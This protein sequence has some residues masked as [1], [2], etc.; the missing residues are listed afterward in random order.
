VGTCTC[1]YGINTAGMRQFS[2]WLLLGVSVACQAPQGRASHDVEGATA[3]AAPS[4]AA[5]PADASTRAPGAPEQ[6]GPGADAAVDAAAL[7]VPQADAASSAAGADGGPSAQN[8]PLAARCM[9]RSVPGRDSPLPRFTQETIASLPGA[10]YLLPH[11]VNRDG[12]PELLVS[13]LT[14]GLDL[15]QLA[16]GPPLSFGGAYVLSR[17]ASTAP[18]VLPTFVVQKAFDQSAGIAW[19]NAS[20]VFDADGDSV[21]DWLIGAGLL[22]KPVGAL[23]MMRGTPAGGFEP[24][25]SIPVP[26]PSCW[27]HEVLPRDLDG[28]GDLDFLTTCH[29]GSASQGGPSRLAWFEN[30]GAGDFVHHGLGEGGGALLSLFDVDGDGDQDVLAPQFFGGKSLVWFELRPGPAL[31]EHVI[32]AEAG[33]GF[34]VRLGDMNGDGRTDIVFG[35]HNNEAAESADAR[36]MGIYWYEVPPANALFALSNWRSYRHTIYEGFEVAGDNNGTSAGAPGMLS[37]GD[38]DGDCD[39]DLAVSGDGDVG[40]YAFL[41]S[42]AGFEKRTL[43]SEAGNLNSGEQHILDLDGDGDMDIAWA[44]FGPNDPALLLT[45]GLSSRVFAFIQQ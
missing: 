8:P 6:P 22:V 37:V 7:I 43:S 2:A 40:L 45:T 10:G 28:D 15:T 26:D 33:R 34:I 30:Q 32:D 13:C 17:Q 14:E 3:D 21:D 27:Y 18:G 4:P 5:A 25:R 1:C 36:T 31:V 16:G 19:P 41:Q 9:G 38:L 11:D 12:Y 23:V 42:S 44:V 20:T 39:L 24:P 29:V 35:N